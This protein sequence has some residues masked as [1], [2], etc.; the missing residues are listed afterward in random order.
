VTPSGIEIATF[1]FVAQGLIQ[2]RHRLLL[3][4][5]GAFITPLSIN[6]LV[7]NE[8]ENFGVNE[9][10][11]SHLERT[12]YCENGFCAPSTLFANKISHTKYCHHFLKVIE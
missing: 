10:R 2:L 3:I 5:C 8:F 12:V 6:M 9:A 11:M 1:L 4:R 7:H